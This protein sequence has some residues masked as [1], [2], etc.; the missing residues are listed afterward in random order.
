MSDR[1]IGLIRLAESHARDLLGLDSKSG[2][3][4]DGAL[5]DWVEHHGA[6]LGYRIEDGTVIT[7]DGAEAREVPIEELIA[8][9]TKRVR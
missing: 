6:K 4:R 2:E 7:G 5:K 9:Y 1:N 8:A 3:L